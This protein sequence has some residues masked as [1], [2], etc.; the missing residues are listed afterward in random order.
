MA[1][2]AEYRIERARVQRS[3]DRTAAGYDAAAVLQREVARRMAERLDLV[4]LA[5]MRILDVG[6][7]TGADLRL[8]ARRYPAAERIGLDFSQAMLRN[9]RG[10]PS[11]LARLLPPFAAREAGVVCAAAQS[12]PLVANSMGLIW[13][14]FMLH[15]LD[16]PLSALKEMH[17][18][19]QVDSLLMFA[20]LGPDTLKELRTA[21]AAADNMP[22][23]Q[24]FI[25]MHDLGDMLVESGYTDPVMDMEY[26]TLTYAS[27]EDFL[28]DLR[29]AGSSNALAGRQRGLTGGK[30]WQRMRE[31]LVAQMRDGRLVITF[32]IVYGHAWKPQPR[33]AA[34]GRQI[35]RFDTPR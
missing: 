20:T 13:S 28:R 1:L 26:L 33:L 10:R 11:W 17:R 31:A 7:G 32:E 9:A 5:P 23:V 16:D 4:K 12:L 22:H 24:R 19:L 3:F 35:I 8:L 21:F 2:P 27:P 30:A 14:N 29:G 34:D 25:D 15:W 6:C 18:V